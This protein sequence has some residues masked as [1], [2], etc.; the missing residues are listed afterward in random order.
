MN[1]ETTFQIA[2]IVLFVI[3]VSISGYFRRRAA[4]AGAKAGDKINWRGEGV[5]IMILLRVFG[6]AMWLS[7]LAYLINPRWMAWSALPLPAWLRWVGA[8]MVAVAIP[9]IVWMF[10]SLGHNVTDTVAIRREHTLVTHGP[11]GYIR[12]PLYTFGFLL[13]LGFILLAANW[14]IALSA[15]LALGPLAARTPIEEAKLV[16]QFGDE[17]REY[18]QRT[19][20]FLPP[21]KR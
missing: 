12:H 3:V 18:M 2:G 21:F 5:A 14:F 4:K 13:F 17:Y 9:L 8:A 7:L 1:T 20:R 6:F 16:E 10:R 11:Y 19:G 15:I